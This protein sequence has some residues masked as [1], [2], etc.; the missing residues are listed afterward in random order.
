MVWISAI[1]VLGYLCLAGYCGWT[2]SREPARSLI[3]SNARPSSKQG[4]SVW[5]AFYWCSPLFFVACWQLAWGLDLLPQETVPSPSETA[6]AWLEAVR[7]GTLVSETAISLKRIV[8][9]FGLATVSGVMLGLVAGTFRFARGIV[10]PV[11]SLLR[12]VPPTAFIALLIVYFGIDEAYKYAVVFLGVFFF[13]VQMV[14]DAVDDIDRSY[15]E[16]GQTSGLSQWQVFSRTVFPWSLPR[17]IDVLRINLSAAW[18]FLVAA[19]LI[20]AERGLGHFLAI[21]QRFNRIPDLYACIFTFALIGLFSD[22]VIEWSSRKLFRWYYISLK[23]SDDRPQLSIPRDVVQFGELAP[24]I[25]NPDAIV[26]ASARTVQ[27]LVDNCISRLSEVRIGG[28]SASIIGLSVILWHAYRTQKV[29]LDVERLLS[30]CFTASRDPSFVQA[31]WA[32]VLA[33][34]LIARYSNRLPSERRED[35]LIQCQRLTEKIIK[36]STLPR[37]VQFAGHALNDAWDAN[38]K[39]G[40]DAVVEAC[41]KG[42]PDSASVQTT[43]PTQLKEV[44]RSMSGRLPSSM[45][46]RER[47]LYRLYLELEGEWYLLKQVRFR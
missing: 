6:A 3:I 1:I 19:E 43:P 35:V 4:R 44:I 12:Y 24:I 45:N 7:N 41:L 8:V 9:G 23:S 33:G 15:L 30:L 2:Y 40:L 36:D 22:R 42:W 26:A 32:L 39:C 27:R 14:I 16:M 13:I 25:R 21:S 31:E 10:E 20:G 5:K 28:R 47:S 17:V 37:A 18:T 29:K 46:E 11:N 34:V 38:F